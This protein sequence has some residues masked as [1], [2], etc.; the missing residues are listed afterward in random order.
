MKLRYFSRQCVICRSTAWERWWQ[1]VYQ[2]Q[3]WNLHISIWSH[4]VIDLSAQLSAVLKRQKNIKKRW[5]WERKKNITNKKAVWEYSWKLG[6]S[7]KPLACSN[8]PSH[9]FTSICRLTRGASLS[10]TLINHRSR[11]PG[12]LSTLAATVVNK[13]HFPLASGLQCVRGTWWPLNCGRQQLGD[14]NSWGSVHVSAR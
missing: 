11:A 6:P 5:F 14:A 2:I 3:P 10:V 4:T 9:A 1:I 8:W 7:V 13:A 12:G